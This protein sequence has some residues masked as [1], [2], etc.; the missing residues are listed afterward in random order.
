MSESMLEMIFLSVLIFGFLGA[1]IMPLRF[2]KLNR[3]PF[4]GFVVGILAGMI[5]SFVLL[6][7]LWFLLPPKDTAGE[8][9]SLQRYKQ[10]WGLAFISPWVIGFLVFYLVPMV[11]SL[12]FSMLDFNLAVPE[13]LQ[14]VGFS[15]WTRALGPAEEVVPSF[16]KT[17]KFS[18]ITL[19]VGLGFSLF[20][21]LLLN[22][23]HV[24]GKNVLRTLFYAP[25]MVPGI[26]GALIW[27]GVLNEQTGWVNVFIEA[28]TGIEAVGVNGLRWTNDP[29][30]VYYAYTLLGLWGVGNSMIIMLAGLQGV[31]TELYESAQIDGASYMQRLL[32][33]TL[34]MIS[35]V[36][37]YNLVVGIIG[38]MGYF[39]VPFLL[40][41]GDGSPQGVTRFIAV[42]FYKQSFAFFNM[43]YGATIAWMIF[44]IALILTVVVF[45]S[46]R[47]WVYYAGEDSQ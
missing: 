32:K 44:I 41:R 25:M 39:D 46:A 47:Y 15:N 4:T 19:P 35:P 27:N 3:K 13:E 23:E 1:L 36:I 29:Q 43:G 9:S 6:T 16:S 33:I 20:L 17:F 38:L 26:A 2:A 31:P 14:F 22:S 40:N 37:F 12:V 8:A 24:K 11:A 10:A 45:G 28:L 34:P 5:G 42:L 7:L 18:A 21:A 30:L